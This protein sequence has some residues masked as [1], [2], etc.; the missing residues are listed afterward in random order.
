VTKKSKLT[1]IIL[2]FSA[3]AILIIAGLGY[4]FEPLIVA[5]AITYLVFP[6]IKKL[7]NRGLNRIVA[8]SVIF[9]A[10]SAAIIFSVMAF[11]PWLVREGGNFM[12]ELPEN[13]A[14]AVQM[15]EAVAAKAGINID[16]SSHGVD[17]TVK[18]QAETLTKGI[19][20]KIQGAISGIFS[21]VFKWLLA[22][23]NVF[24]VP[25]FIVFMINDYEKIKHEIKNYIP[26]KYMPVAYEYMARINRI[27]DGYI[28]GKLVVAV[29]LGLLYGAGLHFIGL[30]YGF[31]IGFAA[32][33]LSI[34]PYVG[35]LIGFAAAV[36]MALAYY[37]GPGLLIGVAAVFAVA[38]LLESYIITPHF[39]GNSVGLSAFVIIVSIIIG[40][41]LMGVLGIL[42]AIPVAAMLKETLIDL[43]EHYH[44]ILGDKHSKPVKSPRK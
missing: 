26:K 1:V 20:A 44:L 32:G 29:I 3:I 2:C 35:S 8:V 10:L 23:L 37:T 30:K 16:L 6:M 41:N 36:I 9:L 7:E 31:V 11:V 4:A 15:T 21:N 39:V 38:Q 5:F 24:L 19:M 42:I 40:G 18:S 33:V 25:L 13:S 43:R 34:I 28:R 17:S 14:K 12:V 22:L 27:L